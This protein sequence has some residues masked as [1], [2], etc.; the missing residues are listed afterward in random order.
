MRITILS[1]AFSL[2]AVSAQAFDTSHNDNWALAGIMPVTHSLAEASEKDAVLVLS[3][4]A[5]LAPHAHEASF[6][7]VLTIKDETLDAAPVI[8]RPGAKAIAQWLEP[9]K[10]TLISDDTARSYVVEPAPESEMGQII[11]SKWSAAE[12]LYMA[13]FFKAHQ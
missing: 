4:Q 10:A 3:E 9:M 7:P 11:D 1:V 5:F 13:D 6:D 12:N 8:K 2:A